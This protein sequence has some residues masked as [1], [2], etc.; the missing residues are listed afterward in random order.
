[1]PI[2]LLG[3]IQYFLDQRTS[4]S[5]EITFSHLDIHLFNENKLL[6]RIVRENAKLRIHAPPSPGMPQMEVLDHLVFQFSFRFG[7]PTSKFSFESN[8]LGMHDPW[9]AVFYRSTPM[10]WIYSSPLRPQ[11]PNSTS[12]YSIVMSILYI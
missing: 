12:W 8:A 7:L 5:L 6:N 2:D 10:N 4:T 1:M 3:E 9:L 11:T